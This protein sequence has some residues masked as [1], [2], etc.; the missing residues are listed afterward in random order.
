MCKLLRDFQIYSTMR[1]GASPAGLCFFCTLILILFA[2][3]SSPL[4]CM[5]YQNVCFWI[6]LQMVTINF[7]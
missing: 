1:R 5:L 3:L 2:D 4:P 7:C 6:D